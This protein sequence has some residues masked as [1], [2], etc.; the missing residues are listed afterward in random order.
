M[1]MKKKNKFW[2]GLL[3]YCMVMLGI[4]MCLWFVAWNYAAAYEMAQPVGAMNAY[5][6]ENLEQQLA[7]AVAEYS[8]AHA[9]EYQS[10]E[11]V[12]QVL[13][14]LV[15]DGEW[16]Y[17]KNKE[18]KSNAP[19][20]T[21][22]SGDLA[23]GKVRLEQGIAYT[24]DFG[25][26]PWEAQPIE[27]ELEGLERSAT[28]IAPADCA[29][30]VN[31][32][33]LQGSTEVLSGYPGFEEYET[34]IKEEMDLRV[35]RVEGL[36]A[37]DLVIESGSLTVAAAEEPDTWYVLPELDDDTL[38]EIEALAPK[39]IDAYLM[40]T[41]NAGSFEAVQPYLAPEGELVDRLRRSLDGLS[42]VKYTTG[43]VLETE[44]KNIAYYGNV[45][46]YEASYVLQL[47]SGDMDGN[48]YVVMVRGENGWRVSDIELF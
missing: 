13:N 16:S 27:L 29:V 41:S 24:L 17:R 46:T 42:W 32:Y 12:A 21:V 7:D 6:A 25:Q 35:Y 44:I 9:N 28:V 47:K 11:D 43:K 39:F 4:T 5:M 15:M 1:A 19:V 40:F 22:Y 18:Y 30:T 26:E 36:I 3:I 34:T 37:K 8:E 48:M 23:L 20:Y 14:E 31:G 2:K 10:A 33:T 45:A 38:A